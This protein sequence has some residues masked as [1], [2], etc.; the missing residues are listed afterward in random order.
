MHKSCEKVTPALATENTAVARAGPVYS[1][2]I[3][4]MTANQSVRSCR[5]A[6]PENSGKLSDELP[7]TDL[8]NESSSEYHNLQY[9]CWFLIYPSINRLHLCFFCLSFVTLH[10]IG[11]SIFLVFSVFVTSLLSH[12]LCLLSDLRH[13]CYC[14][15]LFS[16]NSRFAEPV[17]T[18]AQS[19]WVGKGTDSTAKSRI[20]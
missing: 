9:C 13:C 11:K 6:Q 19:R 20:S 16:V 3:T 12:R 10:V 7:S 2:P 17:H 1:N 15:F 5:N 18:T 8:R 4:T 14:F